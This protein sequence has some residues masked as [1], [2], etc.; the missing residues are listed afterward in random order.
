MYFYHRIII[1]FNLNAFVVC[2]WCLLVVRIR[3]SAS[4]H[5]LACILL[6][7]IP[8]FILASFSVSI[9]V[10][11]GM[12]ALFCVHSLSFSATLSLSSVSV[13]FYLWP[14]SQHDISYVERYAEEDVRHAISLLFFSRPHHCFHLPYFTGYFICIKSTCGSATAAPHSFPVFSTLSAGTFLRVYGKHNFTLLPALIHSTFYFWALAFV[15]TTIRHAQ[16]RLYV[17][18]FCLGNVVALDCSRE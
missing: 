16:R 4:L 5:H 13:R 7:T 6:S 17:R 11:F 12:F 8:H 14:S 3:P 18:N 2:F 9:F 10:F 15:T 1:Y